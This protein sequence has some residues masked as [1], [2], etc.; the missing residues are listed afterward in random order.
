MR[1]WRKIAIFFIPLAFDA[2]VWAPRQ[3]IAISVAHELYKCTILTCLLTVWYEKQLELCGYPTVKKGLIIR[4]A[5]SIEYWSVTDR[6][7]DRQTD[8]HLSTA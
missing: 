3:N 5:V 6:Q 7:T 8:G 4:L 2:P 1:Y